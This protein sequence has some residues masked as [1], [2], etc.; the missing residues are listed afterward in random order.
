MGNAP[1]LRL[2]DPASLVIGT[3]VREAVALD[4][5][6]VASIRTHGVMQPIV[7]IEDEDGQLVVRMGQRRTLAAA[8]VGLGAIPV[9][10]IAAAHADEAERIVAQMA[11]NDHRDAITD[12]DRAEAYQQLALIGL[13]PGQI[14]RRT[15]RS[16]AEVD[17]AVA[18]KD[19][20]AARRAL[21]Q[22]LT[23][24]DAALVAEFE[25]DEQAVRAILE[26]AAQG[27]AGHAAQRIRDERHSEECRLALEAALT[28]EGCRV[29]PRPRSYYYPGEDRTDALTALLWSR[30][31]REAITAA[32]HAAECPGHAAFL[33]PTWGEDRKTEPWRAIYCC[34]E[35]KRH[36]RVDRPVPTPMSDE[37]KA[38]RR[39]VIANNKA[40]DAAEAVRGEWIADFGNG[41]TSPKDAETFL[42]AAITRGDSFNGY[43]AREA[44]AKLLAGATGPRHALRIAV[45]CLLAQWHAQTSRSTWRYPSREDAAYLSAMIGWGYTASDVEKLVLARQ[46]N[47]R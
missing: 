29:V 35:P 5:S 8:E 1:E 33:E 40:W 36:T 28:A 12:A 4:K 24:T 47:R 10:V 23:L 6:F 46:K 30:K 22:Q 27:Q 45:W 31:E 11:E 14:A 21:D 25:D 16:K 39:E 26:A 18:I 38:E 42:A 17:A 3:N 20:A 2:V 37:E 44:A 34:T 32:R 19:S 41:K 7:A 15:G 9:M 13:T 43:E